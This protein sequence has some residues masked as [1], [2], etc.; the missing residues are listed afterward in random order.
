MPDLRLIIAGLTLATLIGTHLWAYWH[1]REAQ[2][3]IQR[4]DYIHAL[5]AK[6]EAIQRQQAITQQ[7]THDH[8]IKVAELD[9]KYR[10]SVARVGVVR[11][12]P[13]PAVSV[14]QPAPA[15][16]GAISATP[17]AELPGSPTGDIGPALTDLVRDADTC[18]TRLR[19][20]QAWVTQQLR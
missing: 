9:A 8:Q 11:V 16:G 2:E 5:E 6:D 18:A 17:G 10:D 1:G 20:L 19:S 12:C 3:D 14:P 13:R 15:T 4:Q 7:V